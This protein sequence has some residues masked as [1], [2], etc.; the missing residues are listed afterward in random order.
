MKPS[1]AILLLLLSSK[2]ALASPIAKAQFRHGPEHAGVFESS[3]PGNLIKQVWK[4][5]AGNRIVASPVISDGTLFV[6]SMGGELLAVDSKSGA[7]RWRFRA[8]APISSTV[9]VV[10]G[11]VVFQSNANTIFAVRSNDGTE[12]WRRATGPSVPFF[13]I[14]AFPDAPDYDLWASS[15]LVQDE[16]IFIG[17]GDGNVYAFDLSSGEKRWSFHTGGRVRAT[18]ASDGASVFVGS[19]DGTMYSLDPGSGRLKWKYKTEGNSYFPIGSIQSS[20]VVTNG[21]IIFGSRDYNLYAIDAKSGRLAW[22]DLHKDSWVVASPAVA[23]GRVY[24]GSSDARFI[25]CSDAATGREIWT[26]PMDG[27][28]FSSAAIV[29]GTLYVGTFQGTIV[30]MKIENGQSAGIQLQDRIYASPW[31]ESGILYVATN[32]GQIYALTNGALQNQP[33]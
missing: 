18:P 11:T 33:Q 15:P 8:D 19:F 23:N 25:R 4:F 12:V 24:V 31:I 7:L 9:A 6:G 13:S 30:R 27:N 2:D 29:D 3:Q 32:D 5:D 14:P 20:A 22:K 21:K 26:K 10:N 1:L 28:V 17:S 16:A